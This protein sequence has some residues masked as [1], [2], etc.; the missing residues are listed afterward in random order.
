[1]LKY[2]LLFFAL[3]SSVSSYTQQFDFGILFQTSL[4]QTIAENQNQADFDQYELIDGTLGAG[5]GFFVDYKANEKLTWR[6]VPSY[7]RKSTKLRT[8][9]PDVANENQAG[10]AFEFANFEIPFTGRYLIPL[11]RSR[12][13]PF[14]GINFGFY[15]FDSWLIKS[16][17]AAKESNVLLDEDILNWEQP[18]FELRFVPGLVGGVNFTPFSSRISCSFQCT[19]NSLN[20]FNDPVSIPLRNI[21]DELNTHNG[22]FNSISFSLG[23]KLW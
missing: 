12:I 13:E 17:S 4:N 15:H 9:L 2:V 20:Y 18:S 6:I 14:V 3:L 21:H 7:S 5:F 1:M 8:I 19:F 16:T 23:Y 11:G 22:R 10:F